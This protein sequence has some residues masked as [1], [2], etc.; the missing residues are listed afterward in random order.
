MLKNGW[1]CDGTCQ[2]D[3]PMNTPFLCTLD[4]H[5]GKLLGR[6]TPSHDLHLSRPIMGRSLLRLCM[7]ATLHA[8]RLG[9]RLSISTAAQVWLIAANVAF[10]AWCVPGV[11][12]TAVNAFLH[13]SACLASMNFII[14][15]L[16]SALIEKGDGARQ[17]RRLALQWLTTTLQLVWEIGLVVRFSLCSKLKRTTPTKITSESDVYDLT[18][19][20]ALETQQPGAPPRVSAG[21][22]GASAS[23]S[24]EEPG[25]RETIRNPVNVRDDAPKVEVVEAGAEEEESDADRAVE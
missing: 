6:F 5:M 19:D 11:D 18:P 25:P 9:E 1:A 23:D 16:L 14:M 17:L 12:L 22:D 10:L 21:D 13:V 15:L 2:I 3:Q 24:D 20:G 7:R 8:S 4:T